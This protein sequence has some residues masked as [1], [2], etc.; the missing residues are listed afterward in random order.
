MQAGQVLSSRGL[1]AHSRSDLGFGLWRRRVRGPPRSQAHLVRSPL[2]SRPD[3]P[4]IRRTLCSDGLAPQ[5]PRLLA[6]LGF[7]ATACRCFGWE[8][9]QMCARQ[10]LAPPDPNLP[11]TTS[12]WSPPPT[13][14]QVTACVACGRHGPSVPTTTHHHHSSSGG[15]SR[16][17]PRAAAPRRSRSRSPRCGCSPWP[18]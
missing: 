13:H 1:R 14:L 2:I 15:L 17:F 11:L 12:A 18:R 7:C 8:A 4:K 5:W 9:A 16:P 3:L 10:G 6:T